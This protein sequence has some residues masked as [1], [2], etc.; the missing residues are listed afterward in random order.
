[1]IKF[2][3]DEIEQWDNIENVDLFKKNIFLIHFKKYQQRKEK[4][5]NRLYSILDKIMETD[6][7]IQKLSILIVKQ[8][9]S[10]FVK[11]MVSFK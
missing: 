2:N 10:L 5:Q 7:I 4:V 9:L 11:N 8:S 3:K 6:I 1:M